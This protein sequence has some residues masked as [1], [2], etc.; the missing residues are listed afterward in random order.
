MKHS[1]FTSFCL[2]ML[3]ILV[4]ISQLSAQQNLWQKRSVVSPEI[5]ADGSVTIRLYAPA[6]QSVVLNGDFAE[7]SKSGQM[8]M[9]RNDEG[10]WEYRSEP[11]ASELYCYWF[12]TPRTATLCVTWARR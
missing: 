4:G 7:G 8:T 10:V 9:I 11:L 5:G 12:S 2:L 6:A 1:L 3:S